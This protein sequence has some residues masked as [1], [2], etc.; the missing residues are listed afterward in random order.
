MV[1][2]LHQ[3][4]Q[5]IL[6]HLPRVYVRRPRDHPSVSDRKRE[7]RTFG[8][9]GGGEGESNRLV[10]RVITEALEERMINEKP[11]EL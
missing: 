2:E 1:S 4:R 3:G 9:L 10:K 7:C 8:P 5:A 6:L 11:P